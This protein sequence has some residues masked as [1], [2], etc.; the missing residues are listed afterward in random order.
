MSKPRALSDAERADLVAFLDGELAGEAKR[1]IEARINVDPVWRAEAASLKRAWD[2]LDYL[3]QPEP[4]PNFTQRT[5][6]RLAPIRQP[7]RTR[8]ARQPARL[9]LLRW[10]GLGSGWAAA[11][12]LAAVVAYQLFPRGRPHGPGEAELIRDLRIIEN[13]RSYELVHDLDT[14]RRLDQPDLFG[15][16]GV[17]G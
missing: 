15:E 3:P 14:L 6:S 5:M 4:S 7:P 9:R 13:K 1:T 10:M 11:A 17:G 16:D 2:L 8:P 12:V